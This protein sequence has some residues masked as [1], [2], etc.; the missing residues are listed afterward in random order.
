MNYN[1]EYTQERRQLIR[2]LKNKGITDVR[3]LDAIAKVPRHLFLDEESSQLE[4]AYKDIALPIGEDQTIS[5]PY[6]VAYQTSLLEVNSTDRILEIGTG[7]GYQA[8]VLSELG[9]TVYSIERRKKLFDRARS[10]LISLGYLKIQLFF[11]D[12]SEGLEKFAPFDK[13]LITTSWHSIPANLVEQLR[14]GGMM[15]VPVDGD[16]HKM[17]RV[18]RISATEYKVQA[19]DDFKFVPYA[20]GHR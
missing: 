19:F 5:E 14:V 7:S 13:I 6:M 15:V 10:I 4:D 18:L 20:A 11:G 17:C 12:G 3:I 1:G 16:V 9:A 2:N 8:A